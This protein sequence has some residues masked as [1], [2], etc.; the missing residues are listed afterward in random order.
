MISANH[1]AH[2]LRLAWRLICFD[3][4]VV[5]QMPGD[6]ASAR[7]S[8][9]VLWFDFPF[10]L[11]TGYLVNAVYIE[12]YYTPVLLYFALRA[13]MYMFSLV[14]GLL[15]VYYVCRME[16]LVA[17]FPRWIVSL[18]WLGILLDI[19][20]LPVTLCIAFEWLPRDQLV[21]LGIAVYLFTI[22]A[23]WVNCWRMLKCNP[24]L[25]AGLAILPML[26]SGP[27]GDLSNLKLFGVVRPFFD[28][29]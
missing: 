22:Y 29:P 6:K 16:G 7:R 9:R 1:I 21:T 3:A 5:E 24:F 4:T 2:Q 17:N 8:F 19:L 15:A 23:A 27:L 28:V 12:K 20:L 10:T 13:V 14:A 18:N 26:I 25:A 11:L